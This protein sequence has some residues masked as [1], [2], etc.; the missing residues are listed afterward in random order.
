[1]LGSRAG[2]FSAKGF[3]LIEIL[4]VMA[5][6][7]A[8]LALGGGKLMDK[9]GNYRSHVRNIATLV[10]SIRNNARLF[11][12]TCR[13]ELTLDDEK[14]HSYDVECASGNTLLLTEEQ[15]VEQERLSSLQ[16]EKKKSRFSREPRVLKKIADLPK[17][18][19]FGP[20]EFADRSKPVVAGH[21]SIYFFPQGLVQE[22]AIHLTD[23]K[24]LNWTIAL[25]PLT[26]RTDVLERNVSLKDL[27][28][29]Q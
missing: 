16:R 9:T 18:L 21:A 28:N 13:L 29:V 26:G 20:I 19:F 4:I 5:I 24:N 14:G 6:I 23:R 25:N 11:N 8:A 27:R 3:T 1:M 15:E 7:A 17:G 12:S 22:A 2:F 10:R